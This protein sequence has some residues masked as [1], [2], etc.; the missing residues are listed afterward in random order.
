M[1]I[2]VF[3]ASVITDLGV[4]GK[5]QKLTHKDVIDAAEKTAPILTSLIIKLITG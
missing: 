2:H 3:A 1:G 4:P 5:I